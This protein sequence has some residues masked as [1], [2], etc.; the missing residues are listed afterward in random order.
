MRQN[1]VEKWYKKLISSN[2]SLICKDI[3]EEACQHV[4]A[5][6]FRIIISN[7]LTK[8][9]DAL[10]SPKTVLVWLMTYL[11]VPVSIISFVV[12][13]REAGSMLP[14]IFIAS[15][16]RKRS[17]RKW[18]WVFGS[19]LQF[20]CIA[21]ISLVSLFFQGVTAGL[22]ILVFLV[23]FSLAR[24]LSS[25]ASKDV[26]GKSIPKKRRGRLNGFST[27]LSGLLVLGAGLLIAFYFKENQ[28]LAFYSSL[29]LF[30]GFLWLPAAWVYAGIKEFPGE[31]SESKNVLKEAWSRLQL[32]Q[33][34]KDFRNFIIA[35]SLLLCSALTAPFY[36]VLAQEYLGKET[37]VLGLFVLANGIA[38]SLSA[39]FWGRMADKSSKN[40]MVTGAIITAFLGISMYFI[41]SY[42]SFLRHQFLLYPIAVFVLGI[43][44][45]GVRLGR[46]TYVVDMAKGNKRTDYVSASNTIIGFILLLTG[47]LSALTSL[48][49]IEGTI[50]VLSLFGLLGAFASYRLPKV[51]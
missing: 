28:N 24:G 40:V 34:D 1:R 36:V 21:S 46:K 43:A 6:F 18:I 31:T 17:I 15:F 44:H 3:S 23:L 35:R 38:S 7:T 42:S 4:P 37:F 27:A 33:T 32:I 2:D 41:I 45:S 29:I 39:P 20:F 10:S 14:Q 51:E 9:G 11:N 48:I 5:N 50:L 12:P 16:I 8:L 13:I 49:S 26:M 25:V 19:V 22:L 30:A 47:G